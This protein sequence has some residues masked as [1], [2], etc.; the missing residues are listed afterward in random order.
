V[1]ERRMC[2]SVRP[3]R[4]GRAPSASLGRL[5]YGT[6][7]TDCGQSI[8]AAGHGAI[9]EDGWTESVAPCDEFEIKRGAVVGFFSVQAQENLVP[10]IDLLKTSTQR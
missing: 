9:A 4:F 8:R 3:W 5:A 2:L 10:G 1:N 7:S 6:R